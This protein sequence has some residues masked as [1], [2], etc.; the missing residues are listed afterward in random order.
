[1]PNHAVEQGDCLSSIAEQY[2]FFWST[3]WNHAD[4]A[5]L[6]QLRKDPNALLEGDVVVVPDKTVKEESCATEQTHKFKKKGTPAKM[7]IRL[8]LDDK[9]R[10]NEAYKLCIDGKWI[11]GKTDGD[12]YIEADIPAGAKQGELRVGTGKEIDIFNLGFGTLD[13]ADEETGAEDRL[14]GL[15]YDLSGG[16]EEALKSFQTKEKLTVNGQLDDPTKAKLKE[17]Y[18]Q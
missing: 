15:G 4:N 11:E 17:R 7:K 14:L 2:G 5:D 3:L 16:L 9:P 12:G 10:K 13:P 1:M 8:M 6:K 18:G